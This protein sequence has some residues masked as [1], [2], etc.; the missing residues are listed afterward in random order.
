MAGSVRCGDEDRVTDGLKLSG[1]P[2]YPVYRGGTVV[3]ID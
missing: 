1:L 3:I 2:R